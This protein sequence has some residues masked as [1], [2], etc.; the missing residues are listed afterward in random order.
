MAQIFISHS[1]KDTESVNF[2][3]KVFAPTKVKAI[4]EEFDSKLGL[5]VNSQ[6]IR[7]DI[8]NSNAVFILLDKNIEDVKHTRDWINWECGTATG[9]NKHIWV[10]EKFHDIGKISII[11][12]SLTHLVTYSLN[13]EW[14][15]YVRQIVDSYDD[16]NVLGTTLLTTGAGAALSEDKLTGALV[17]LGAGLLLSNLKTNPV[18]N[19]VKCANC[20]SMYNTHIPF[21]T[22][23]RCPVCNTGLQMPI[24]QQYGM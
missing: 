21:G 17:G 10:F 16:S 19:R 6:K 1:A 3:S 15:A 11:T 2:F 18:G 8:E 9:L 7:T 14:Y 5:H 23:F 24:L 12:P 13:D 22:K 4:Y 20:Q